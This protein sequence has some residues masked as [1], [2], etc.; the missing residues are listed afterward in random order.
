MPRYFLTELNDGIQRLADGHGFG[1]NP[2]A[3]PALLKALEALMEFWDEPNPSPVH[4]GAIQVQE[5]R[6]AIDAAIR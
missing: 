1:M 6:N 5:A 4:P 3:A 2:T